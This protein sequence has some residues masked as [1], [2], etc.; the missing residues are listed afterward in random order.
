M[1]AK[2]S[3]TLTDIK[4]HRQIMLMLFVFISLLYLNTVFNDYNLDDELVTINH[5]LT[6]KGINGIPEIFSSPYYQDDMGYN[7]EYRPIVLVTF[8]I[9]HSVFGETPQVSHAINLLL[10]VAVCLLLYSCLT[11]LLTNISNWFILSTVLL[12]A[13]HP[14]HTEV[15]AS[16]KNRDEILTMLGAM[17]SLRMLLYYADKKKP[18]YF[19]LSIVFFLL[20]MFSKKT[21][22]TVIVIMPVLLIL[23][24]NIKLLPLIL[25]VSICFV[26]IIPILELYNWRDV[27]IYFSLLNI[28]VCIFYLLKHNDFFRTLFF[29][30][31]SAVETAKAQIKIDDYWFSITKEQF[32]WVTGFVIVFSASLFFFNSNLFLLPCLVFL[33]LPL[34]TRDDLKMISIAGFTLIA[35]SLVLLNNGYAFNELTLIALLT[36]LDWLKEN[37]KLKYLIIGCIGVIYLSGFL[38]IDFESA[39]GSCFLFL[40]FFLKHTRLKLLPLIVPVITFIGII[41]NAIQDIDIITKD[42]TFAYSIFYHASLIIFLYSGKTYRFLRLAIFLILFIVGLLDTIGNSKTF[43]RLLAP[44]TYIEESKI[45]AI[46]EEQAY[47]PLEYVETVTTAASDFETRFGTGMVILGKYLKLVFLPYPM[48]FYY[49]YKEISEYSIYA[50]LPIFFLVLHFLLFVAALLLINK[51]PIL[52]AGLFIY[53]LAI[54][55]FSNIMFPIPGMMAD[56]FLFVPSLGFSIILSWLIFKVF[57]TS[58][59]SE[60][61]YEWK[62][63]NRNVKYTFL[64]VLVLYSSVT[65]SRNLQWKNHLTLMRHDIKHLE[66][67]A[68]AHNLLATNLMKYSF[69][70]EYAAESNSMRHE[71]IIHFKKALAIYP[72]FFNVYYNLGRAFVVVN[73][74]ESAYPCFIKVHSMDTTLS[75]VTLNIAMIAESRG[76]NNTAIEYYE[77]LIRINPY[78]KHSYSSLSYLYFRLGQYEKSIDVNKKAILYNN[79]WKDPYQNIA[80]VYFHLKDTLQAQRYIQEGQLKGRE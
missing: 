78:V 72:D 76:D 57:K 66:N 27:I 30:N 19:I 2:V 9:E 18:L 44:M 68:Q 51:K 33:L 50:P 71:A 39:L 46:L 55:P 16:I 67:S 22:V 15:V 49:G 79:A 23:F 73:D 7:Y 74:Y 1:L 58:L 35:L 62:S 60:S 13:S 37:K 63:I 53:I 64:A 54:A 48:S 34:F 6:S 61:S 59:S 32:Y 8:A 65:F 80:N 25:F 14:I 36:L 11:V 75:E 31:K 26:G 42:L 69:Y 52:A 4:P 29:Q 28:S 43:N 17:L 38:V 41:W 45:P 12:F 24:R 3:K 21:I 5:R 20:A 47:R 56:R 10:Y 70:K 40:Y 77:K